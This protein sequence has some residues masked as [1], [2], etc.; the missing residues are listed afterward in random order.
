MAGV[1]VSLPA[2]S[3][4][5]IE[6]VWEPTESEEAV[7]FHEKPEVCSGIS[8][9]APLS[10]FQRSVKPS[11]LFASSAVAAKAAV[12]RLVMEAGVAVKDTVGAVVSTV[13]V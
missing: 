10:S 9:Q 8:V 3:R 2:L 12:V 5:L 7:K 13:H 4:A 11:A 1:A 6:T